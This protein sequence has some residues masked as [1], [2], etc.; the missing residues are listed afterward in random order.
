MREPNEGE[1]K[2]LAVVAGDIH[3]TATPPAFRRGEPNWIET[4]R[5]ALA[6]L[7]EVAEE[8]DAPLIITGDIFDRWNAPPEII[9]MAIQEFSK[10][11]LHPITIPGQH[12][13][14]YH[15]PELIEKS[16][17]Y[18]LILAGV[19]KDISGFS[20]DRKTIGLC[21]SGDPLTYC[22]GF[23]WGDPVRFDESA[24]RRQGVRIAVAHQYAWHGNARYKDAPKEAELVPGHYSDF[25][26]VLFGDN[27]RAFAVQNS[28]VTIV[29]PGTLLRRK[30][31]ELGYEPG[32]FAIY[33]DG[34]AARFVTDT[35][36]DIYTH[37]ESKTP[38]GLPSFETV[39]DRLREIGIETLSFVES[40]SKAAEKET[41]PLVAEF[42][43]RS[44]DGNR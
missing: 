37:T 42:L 39:L 10:F 8:L 40:V 19:I 9:N 2:A 6:E 7:R 43:R 14:P 20:Q 25:D 1:V 12:D 17:Y 4:Q 29:N 36:N 44:I 16:A 13:L 34:H 35:E 15:N 21:L 18:S 38:S 22:A 11:K 32:F 24:W 28:P 26:F 27:H 31:D 41:D 30:A 5:A 3:L 23:K 33:S